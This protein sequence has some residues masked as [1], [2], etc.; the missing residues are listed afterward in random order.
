MPDSSSKPDQNLAT[1]GRTTF[2]LL[3]LINERLRSNIYN[4]LINLKT[5]GNNQP[6]CS[7]LLCLDKKILNRSSKFSL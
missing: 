1:E 5:E 7:D 6:R 2:F 3:N 4:Y